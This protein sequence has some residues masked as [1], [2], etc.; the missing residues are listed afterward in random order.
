MLWQSMETVWETPSPGGVGQWALSQDLDG[1]EVQ[2]DEIAPWLVLN[3]ASDLLPTVQHWSQLIAKPAD[4]VSRLPAVDCRAPEL[5]LDDL[6][7]DER[8]PCLRLRHQ[9]EQELEQLWRQPR[10]FV[11]EYD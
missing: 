11:A 1:C 9:Q 4:S 3:E 10:S 5:A 7:L 8:P 6:V 2:V